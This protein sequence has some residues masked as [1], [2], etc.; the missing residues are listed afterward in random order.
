MAQRPKNSAADRER[1]E[2]E[3][4]KYKVDF[5]SQTLDLTDEQRQ[6]F[7]PMYTE[8]DAKLEDLQRN[9][10][11]K[12]QLL[13]KKGDAATDSEYQALAKEEFEMRANE[14]RIEMS[15]YPKFKALLSSRQLYRLKHAERKFMRNLME[16][17]GNPGDN[18]PGSGQ[19]NGKGR[20]AG[21]DR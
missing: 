15:Y 5:I 2:Q 16:R 4:R 9:L 12:E 1:W 8:M 14:S 21:A 13:R 20:G 10:R 18:R 7:E 17:K 11:D 19:T 3:M 6:K